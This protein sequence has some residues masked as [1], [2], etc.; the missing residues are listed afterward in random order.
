M[1]HL[2]P[3]SYLFS[4]KKTFYGTKRQLK[5]PVNPVK[6]DVFMANVV[7]SPTK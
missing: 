5:D 4:K 3:K 2:I 7:D 1:Y 6:H